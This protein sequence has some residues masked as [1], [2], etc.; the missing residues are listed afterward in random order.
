MFID[1]L[2]GGGPV[3]TDGAWG[4]QLQSFG[5]SGGAC[6]D[7]WNLSHP[8]LVER[9]PRA[10][11]DAGSQVVLTN[12]FRANRIA[13]AHYDLADQTVDINRIG[14]EISRRAVGDRARVFATM[15]PC[16]KMLVAGETSREELRE[17]FGEQAGA[18]AAAGADAIV[19]ETMSDVN[20][21]E[22]ALQA[23]KETG[24]P[25][26]ACLVFDSGPNGDCTMTGV[27]PEEATR[28]LAAAGA[29]V[30]GANCGHGIEGYID[31]C[32]R[33][34]AAT[35]K[36]LWIKP[37]AG[38]P[39]MV[40]GEVVYRTTPAEFAARAPALLEAGAQFLGG[41]CGTGPDFIAALCRN[42]PPPKSRDAV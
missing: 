17:V 9:V 4:T 2:I 24:L 22:V 32:R 42:V 20:E 28:W 25:V 10:Y 21:A 36:P 26:V 8:E 13:L 11:V 14:V 39:E 34:R 5:L 37:N 7:Q 15:G 6:P 40:K 16:G 31:I 1:E 35:D 3:I 30:V 12:T 18:L 29:D 33:M 27:S 23:A 38:T 19:V 41:C